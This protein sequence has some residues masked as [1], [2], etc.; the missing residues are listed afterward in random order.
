MS[1]DE[2]V[3]NA[4]LPRLNLIEVTGFVEE[5]DPR[6]VEIGGDGTDGVG[7]AFLLGSYAAPLIVAN[8]SR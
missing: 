6:L 7:R 3:R 4:A 1:V 5:G 2:P 8:R